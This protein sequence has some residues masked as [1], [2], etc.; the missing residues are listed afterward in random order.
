MFYQEEAIEREYDEIDSKV[1]KFKKWH[2]DC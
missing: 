1:I 2:A